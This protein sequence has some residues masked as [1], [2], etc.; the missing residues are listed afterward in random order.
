MKLSK[1]KLRKIIREE[2]TIADEDEQPG[3]VGVVEIGGD[4]LRVG[5]NADEGEVT[6]SLNNQEMELT[7]DDVRDVIELMEEAES[8]LLD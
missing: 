8:R 5:L 6:L 1:Q 2:L 3:F 7:L 4:D